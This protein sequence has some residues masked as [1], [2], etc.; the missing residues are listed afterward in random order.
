M[1]ALIDSATPTTACTA[2][3]CTT[4]STCSDGETLQLVM[5]DEFQEGGRS[6]AAGDDDPK[7]TAENVSE[8]RVGGKRLG[9][10][11]DERKG[12]VQH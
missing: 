12:V 1:A 7:W 4:S 5:S 9:R 2:T 8:W 6:F 10:Q 11:S 3:I